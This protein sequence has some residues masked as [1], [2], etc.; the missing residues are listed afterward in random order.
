MCISHHFVKEKIEAGV[1]PTI[2]VGSTTQTADIFSKGL[3][4]SLFQRYVNRLNMINIH[5]QLAG[6]C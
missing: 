4:G 5:A 6:E 1:I 2:F 3:A